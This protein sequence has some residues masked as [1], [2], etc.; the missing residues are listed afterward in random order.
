LFFTDYQLGGGGGGGPPPPAIGASLLLEGANRS[1]PLPPSPGAVMGGGSMAL[2][3]AYITRQHT[4]AR[5]HN[6]RNELPCAHR[7][8]WRQSA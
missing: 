8:H 6:Q 5:T 7:R 2:I 3:V 1:L 4:H